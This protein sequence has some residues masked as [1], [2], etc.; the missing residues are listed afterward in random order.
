MNKDIIIENAIKY[1]SKLP[2]FGPRSAR[3]TI[4]YFLKNK[5]VV[6]HIIDNLEEIEEK[7]GLCEVCFN[8]STLNKCDIC[9]DESRDKSKI[10]IVAE[11]D[12]IWNIEKSGIFNGLYHALGGSLSAVSNITPDKLTF[13]SLFSRFA[14]CNFEEIIFANNLSVEGA[15]TVFYIMDE[16]KKL[17]NN[18]AMKY[19]KITELAN[20]IPMGASL[21]YMD[22]GTIEVAF[23]ARKSI[24]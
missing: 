7:V 2:G 24:L 18:G 23:K 1:F 16:I 12:D 17:Q 19:I 10:C 5:D 15:T 9:L 21:E 13:N 22:E 6:R 14:S 8:I 3:R 11:V 20:G 4:L